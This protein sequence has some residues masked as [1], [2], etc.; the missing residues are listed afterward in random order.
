MST[1]SHAR[2]KSAPSPREI[3]WRRTLER[4]KQSGL[5]GRA[6]CHREGLPEPSFYGWK[7]RLRILDERP[8]GPPPRRSTVRRRDSGNDSDSKVRLLP[9]RVTAPVS[10][11]ELA[12]PGGRTLRIPTDFNPD[13]LARLLAVLEKSPC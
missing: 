4:W 3:E 5:S 11:F 1:N 13:A 8:T 2:F 12:L 6:F 9:V 7:R 10:G